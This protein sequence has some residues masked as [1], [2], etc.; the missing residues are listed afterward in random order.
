MERRETFILTL[1]CDPQP[2]FGL[3]GR[4]RHV[5]TNREQLFTNPDDLIQLLRDFVAQDQEE[6][7]RN[8]PQA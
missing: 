7:R 1:F 8:E 3:R 2:P 4:L 6:E 5:I